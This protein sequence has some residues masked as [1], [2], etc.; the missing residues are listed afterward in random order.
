MM[1][2]TQHA[3]ANPKKYGKRRS[4]GRSGQVRIAHAHPVIDI[5]WATKY[6]LVP[7]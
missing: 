1:L 4:C 7:P 3:A 6:T 2:T 5:N